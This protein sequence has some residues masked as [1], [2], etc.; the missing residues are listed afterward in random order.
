MILGFIILLHDTIHESVFAR[1]RPAATRALMLLYAFVPGFYAEVERRHD[2]SLGGRP[3]I[4][5][6]D[7]RKRGTVQ[8]A[9]CTRTTVR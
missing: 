8:S 5:G 7:P 4:V 3:V 6:G 9:T 1:R 2:A